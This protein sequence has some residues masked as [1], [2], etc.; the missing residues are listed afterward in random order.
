MLGLGDTRPTPRRAHLAEPLPQNGPRT[1]YMRAIVKNGQVTAFD[2]QDSS[3]LTVL[4][5]ANALLIRPPDDPPR[6]V[7]EAVSYID[8]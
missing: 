7:G 5:Q 1:H 4:S 8:I 2:R 3:L 6:A